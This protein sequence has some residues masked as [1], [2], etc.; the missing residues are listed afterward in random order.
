MTEAQ[1]PKTYWIWTV[2]CQMNK[3]DSD[4]VAQT[5]QARGYVPASSEEEADIVVLNSCA[6][7]ESAERRVSGK[8]GNLVAERK[9]RPDRLLVLT[10]CSV[11]PDF[12][13][14]RKRFRGADIYFQPTR[15]DQ[16]TEQL[17]R[18]WPLPEGGV[19]DCASE[20]IE[21]SE[22]AG[23]LAFVPISNG[24]DKFCTYC[25]V[26]YRRGRE[27]S[28]P[29][30]EIVDECGS[31]VKSGVKEITLL[32]QRVNAYGKDFKNGTDL[33]D[34]LTAVNDIPGL[35]RLRFLTS[36]PKDVSDKLI[37]AIAGLDKVCEHLHLPIQSGNDEVLLNMRR[38]YTRADY[39]DIVG[40]LRARAPQLALST[41]IIVGFP[42]E[43]EEQFADTLSLLEEVHFSTVYVAEYSPRQG[44]LSARWEDDVPAPVKKER[45]QRLDAMQQ[46]ISMHQHAGLKGETVEVLMESTKSFRRDMEQWH[47]RTRQNRAV[48]VPR[49]EQ[50]LLGQVVQVR[51]EKVSA[52]AMQGAVA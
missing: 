32:G 3:V 41:D 23:P 31:L 36:Y 13:A 34:L 40:R 50:D 5:M 48:F 45:K 25:I 52:F 1:V 22:S 33:A 21:A 44:T 12:E 16:F 17:E 49:G 8:L 15:L 38:G 35:D 24:C 19:L 14:T 43:T 42:G 28:R 27:R 26:P 30:M 51:I 37:D 7:R 2:G 46:R 47:G 9:D 4:R 29:L 11:S 6:V 20:Q 39:L 18:I 10:G